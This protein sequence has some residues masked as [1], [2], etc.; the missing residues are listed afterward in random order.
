MVAEPHEYLFSS[1]G[2]CAGEKEYVNVQT[3]I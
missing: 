3:E 2:D 1:A